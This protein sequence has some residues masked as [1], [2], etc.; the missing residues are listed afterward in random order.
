MAG[1]DYIEHLIRRRMPAML[2][3]G[4]RIRHVSDSQLLLEDIDEWLCTDSRNL[5]MWSKY[6]LEF[7]VYSSNISQTDEIGL[8]VSVR[9]IYSSVLWNIISFFMALV[10]CMLICIWTMTIFHG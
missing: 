3:R 7:D 5:S 10:L 8:V 6:K 2:K 4:M 9:I 1:S